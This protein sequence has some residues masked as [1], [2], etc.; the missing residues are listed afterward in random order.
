MFTYTQSLPSLSNFLRSA[1]LPFAIRSTSAAE[2][3][4]ASELLP[5]FVL[6]PNLPKTLHLQYLHIR[7]VENRDYEEH[8]RRCDRGSRG[9]RGAD[10]GTGGIAF[11]GT[12]SMLGPRGG[13]PAG[14]SRHRHCLCR[15][16]HSRAG[17][18]R[19]WLCKSAESCSLRAC[20]S[21][22]SVS[23]REH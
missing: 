9:W 23:A 14:S 13:I 2:P 7:V 10:I 19:V 21:S 6:L 3:T 1:S 16:L 12:P 15:R 11:T 17:K 5:P 4:S 22:R 8:S 20:S 18:E